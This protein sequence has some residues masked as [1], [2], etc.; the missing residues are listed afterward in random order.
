MSNLI[1]FAFASLPPIFLSEEQSLL[2]HSLTS[3]WFRPILSLLTVYTFQIPTLSVSHNS[4]YYHFPT[5][6]V[7]SSLFQHCDL[8]ILA[9]EY[10]S[11]TYNTLLNTS[12]PSLCPCD[13]TKLPI[14]SYMS[15]IIP[16]YD[17]S[18]CCLA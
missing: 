1:F 9:S 2:Y 6:L 5:F 17:C 18:H 3:L 16:S 7:S 13:S 11:Y 10:T 4:M 14:Y 15:P 12:F 8:Y